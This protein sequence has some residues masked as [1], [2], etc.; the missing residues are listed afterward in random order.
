MALKTFRQQLLDLSPPWLQAALSGAFLEITLGFVVDAIVDLAGVA[1]RQQWIKD[2]SV[3]VDAL[4]HHGRNFSLRRLP[5]ET[6]PQFIERLQ[7]AW[8]TWEF[9]GH[10][11]I[12]EGA[13]ATLGYPGIIFD[14]N[15]LNDPSYWSRFV[16]YFAPGTHP[17]I[18]AGLTWGTFTFGGSNRFGPLGLTTAWVQSVQALVATFKPADWIC[19][20][21]VLQ[22]SGWA[23]GTGHTWGEAG[24][25][26]GG[27]LVS[28][29]AH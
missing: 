14:P 24:L 17:A 6:A 3:A 16:L 5:I 18:G 23:Y 11:S 22:L 4:P 26:W 20:D 27:E 21:I 25:F 28:I 15:E 12:I 13:L 29:G 1:L 7:N 10:E 19:S 9:A 2:P 8:Q